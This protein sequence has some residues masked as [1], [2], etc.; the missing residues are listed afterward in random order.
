MERARA[1]TALARR[2]HE[3]KGVTDPGDRRSRNARVG[4][5]G[6]G[7]PRILTFAPFFDPGAKLVRS[8]LTCTRSLDMGIVSRCQSDPHPELG[9]APTSQTRACRLW[10]IPSSSK[11]GGRLS[12]K[13]LCGLSLLYSFRHASRVACTSSR[14]WNQCVF[15]HSCRSR[16][17][18]DSMKGLSGSHAW[19]RVGLPGGEKQ[20]FTPRRYAQA[21]NAF[22][23]NP[24]P[25]ST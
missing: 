20:I 24:A 7:N 18:K 11:L 16:P 13:G 14:V 1:G 2:D 3:R 4:C 23:E 8:S 17:W 10:R 6:L 9:P 5:H 19:D 15:K 12:A 25:L 22:P 21:S